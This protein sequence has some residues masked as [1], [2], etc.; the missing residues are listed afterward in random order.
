MTRP[1]I[2]KD[3]PLTNRWQTAITVLLGRLDTCDA[4][5]AD[6]KRS[7]GKKLAGVRDGDARLEDSALSPLVRLTAKREALESALQQAKA[8]L[9]AA[10]G[11]MAAL[12][13]TIP[14]LESALSARD[15]AQI[16]VEDALQSLHAGLMK[17]RDLNNAAYDKLRLAAKSWRNAGALAE[18]RP[19]FRIVR[20]D[21][22]PA[23]RSLRMHVPF[24]ENTLLLVGDRSG[25]AAD[26]LF[27]AAD[28]SADM[29]ED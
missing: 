2:K 15:L 14:P 11:K 24:C 9:A 25:R 22:C 26:L 12:S 5:I 16:A 27:A 17:L 7:A 3:D 4:E 6:A 18:L 13:A 8:N 29:D 10:P 23:A 1:K 19:N 20:F 28:N 21:D